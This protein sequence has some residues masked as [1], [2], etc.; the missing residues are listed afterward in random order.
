MRPVDII[1]KKRDGHELSPAEIRFFIEGYT[2]GVVTDYQAS[3]WAMAV[4]LNG[5]TD[6]ETTA[7]TL[8]MAES[9]ETLDL[10]GVVGLA[11]DKHSTGGVGDKTTLG[12]EPSAARCGLACAQQ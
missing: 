5:M 9:G 12:V 4:L 11:L 7:L 8:A 10:S 3:A 1:I 6:Q 2:S